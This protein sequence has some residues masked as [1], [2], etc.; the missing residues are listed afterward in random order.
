[1]GYLNNRQAQ[2]LAR[3]RA[4]A[5]SKGASGSRSAGNAGTAQ[6]RRLSRQEGRV[7][8]VHAQRKLDMD[9]RDED[10][11]AARAVETIR[12]EEL[13]EE[14]ASKN[15]EVERLRQALAKMQAASSMGM[16]GEQRGIGLRV[17]AQSQVLP[18]DER[19][20][21]TSRKAYCAIIKGRSPGIYTDFN[22]AW[23]Q[24]S[25]FCLKDV[26]VFV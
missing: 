3:I 24:I 25:G 16:R 15:E 17:G 19:P 22:H 26:R 14:L 11:G 5:Q 2:S 10:V 8:K 20:L 4:I 12:P 7:R 6:R 21:Q 1:M 23:Q 13:R 18:G 9:S